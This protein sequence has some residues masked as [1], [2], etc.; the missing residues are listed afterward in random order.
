MIWALAKFK[1]VNLDLGKKTVTGG[2][3]GWS[4]MRAI[5]TVVS[6]V[7]PP[8]VNIADLARYANRPKDVWPLMGGLFISKPMVILIG[9]FTTAAGAKRFG[10]ANWNLWDLY[11]LILDSYWGPGTRTA[12]FLGA[13]IQAFATVVT[14]ISS[15]AI[16]IGCDLAGLFPGYF[17]IVRGQ[18]LCNLLIWAVVPWLLVNSAQNFL[19]F[20]GSYLCF[21]TPIIACMMVDYWV[22]R[23]GNFHI[24][25]LYR[26]EPGSPYYYTKGVN[27][28]AYAAWVSG[29]VLVISGI[30][31]AI[32]PGSISQTAVNVYNCG[33][34]LSLT[35]AALVYYL[36]N[37]IFPPKIYPDGEHE[38]ETHAWETMV[39]TEGF[40]PDDDAQ[41]SYIRDRM[42]LGEEPNR[43][44]TP[45]VGSETERKA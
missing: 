7:V 29:V 24:P 4:F 43:F 23:K 38:D 39:S 36:L 35:A 2:D 18:I 41:P 12:V 21:I 20:L 3:L 34:V 26:P 10:V 16:P 30:S 44:M 45:T 22:V 37:L 40:F 15:N 9:L 19:T 5:N 33:F 25:S 31:G 13:F 14:N 32:K 17:T 28:R 1:G 11:S 8:M 6:G 42:I 27:L